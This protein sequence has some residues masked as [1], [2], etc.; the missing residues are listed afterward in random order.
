M[1]TEVARVLPT[2]D[3]LGRGRYRWKAGTRPHPTEVEGGP[4]VAGV[5]LGD[6]DKRRRGSGSSGHRAAAR[7]R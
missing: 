7:I 2:G 1:F 3:R 4:R 6:E 5:G